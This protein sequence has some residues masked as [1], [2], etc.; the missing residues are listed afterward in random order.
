MLTTRADRA[1]AESARTAGRDYA[2]DLADYCA[3]SAKS[4]SLHLAREQHLLGLVPE[5]KDLYWTP[6]QRGSEQVILYFVA[7]SEQD[8]LTLLGIPEVL[9]S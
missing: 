4:Q 5:G 7:G 1:I 8:V 2:V 3:P 6:H 9:S